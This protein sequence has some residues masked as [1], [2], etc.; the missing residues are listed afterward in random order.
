MRVKFGQKL[1]T[2]WEKMPENL[3]G[4]FVTH[5]VHVHSKHSDD[6]LITPAEVF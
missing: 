6:I 1:P 5:T 2:N 4:I 3:G